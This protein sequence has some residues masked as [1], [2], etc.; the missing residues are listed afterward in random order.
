MSSNEPADVKSAAAIVSEGPV[1]SM[2]LL[3]NVEVEVTLEIG[4]RRLRIADI[5]KLTAG[6]TVE[7]SKAAGEPLDVFVNGR[8]L[9]RGEA[10]VVGDRYAVRITEIVQPG[11]SGS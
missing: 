6:Q 5:L 1:A 2:D 7:L 11:R 4:R 8:L 10:I 3:K 9:G